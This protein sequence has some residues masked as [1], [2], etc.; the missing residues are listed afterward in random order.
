[1]LTTTNVKVTATLHNNF[2]RRRRREFEKARIQKLKNW[3]EDVKRIAK[4]EVDFIRSLFKDED[5]ESRSW[6]RDVEVVED[7]PEKDGGVAQKDA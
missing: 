3:H 7:N 6:V 2:G 1:M 4:S 5:I